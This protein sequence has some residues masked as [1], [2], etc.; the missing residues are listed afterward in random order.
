MKIVTLSAA[1]SR[2]ARVL[3]AARGDVVMIQRR[4]K[5]VV[6]LMPVAEARL[7]I[8]SAYAIGAL[9]RSDAMRRLGFTWYG[10]LQNAMT[11][12]RLQIRLPRD[13]E[14]R[15]DRSLEGVFQE[16]Q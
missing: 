8:L 11:S 1:R 14:E 9:S 5:D 16:N 12:A 13:V 2:L 4:R 6:A 3:D 7:C 15:M 10:Q